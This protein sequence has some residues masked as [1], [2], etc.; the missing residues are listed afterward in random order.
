MP[1]RRKKEAVSAALSQTRAEQNQR[2]FELI[3]ERAKAEARGEVPPA[4]AASTLGGAIFEAG[5][6]LLQKQSGRI[7]EVRDS[8]MQMSAME[9]RALE[10]EHT[11]RLLEGGAAINEVL[12]HASELEARRVA[13]TLSAET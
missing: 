6:A 12:Q 3:K 1:N 2:A 10:Q 13:L 11:Q 9:G 5:Q 4:P 7:C 8:L